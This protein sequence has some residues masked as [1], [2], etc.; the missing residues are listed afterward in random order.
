MLIQPLA[1]LLSAGSYVPSGHR[2]SDTPDKQSHDVSP[3]SQCT[4]RLA[5]R[6]QPLGAEHAWR[7]LRRATSRKRA[8]GVW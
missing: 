3:P 7:I 5:R 1:E 6:H 2:L 4:F 8:R